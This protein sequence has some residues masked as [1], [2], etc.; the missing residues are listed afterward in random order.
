M[1]TRI[2]TMSGAQLLLMRV[3]G[4]SQAQPQI[5]RELDR[6]ALLGRLPKRLRRST[7]HRRTTVAQPAGRLVA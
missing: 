4:G 3:L 2:S 5:D 7:G 1:A 6:R